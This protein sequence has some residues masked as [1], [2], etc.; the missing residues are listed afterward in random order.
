MKYTTTIVKFEW[1]CIGEQIVNGLA[2]K[3]RYSLLDSETQEEVRSWSFEADDQ[4]SEWKAEIELEDF[5]ATLDQPP[6]VVIY[7]E[8]TGEFEE[9]WS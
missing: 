5:M 2:Q 8:F 4:E 7:D 3:T 6:M 9:I 1:L